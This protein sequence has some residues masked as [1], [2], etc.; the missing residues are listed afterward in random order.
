MDRY[1]LGIDIG[2]TFTDAT[3]IN[4]GTGELRIG[5]VSSTPKD[6]SVG[7]LNAAHRVLREAR[8]KP[9][10][11]AYVVHGTTVANN[12]IIEGKLASTAF[13]TTDGFRDLLEIQRQIRPSLYDLQFDKP[14]P[15]VPRYLCYGVPGRLDAQGNV[16]TPLDEGAVR[17]VIEQ[18][19]KEK[20]Q[21]VA[22]CALHSYVNPAHE[23][24]TGELIKELFPE[25]MVSL[26]CEVA[27]EVREYFRAS[28]TVINAGL[29][30]IVDRYLGRIEAGLRDSGLEADPLVMQSSGGVLTFEA[31][32]ERPVFL[33]ESGPAAGV[34]AAN[35]LGDALGHRNLISLD[36]GGTTAKIGLI[37]D[38][39]PR[40]T[41]DYEVGAMATA[42]GHGSKGG[43][44]PIRTPVIDLIEIGAGGGSIAWVDSGGGLRVGPH[45]AGADPGPVCYGRGGTEPTV[46][47]ANL[48]LGRLD[49]DYF[50]GGE[51][52]LDAEGA[53]RAISEKCADPLGLDLVKVAVGI[54]EIANTAMV[55]ALKRISVQRGFDPRDFVMVCFGGAGPAHANRL[56][57]EMD[58]P[59]TMIPMSPGTTSALGLLVT[60]L[61]H[62]YSTALI[63]RADRLDLGS[64]ERTFRSMEEQGRQLLLRERTPEDKISFLRQADMRYVGQSYE[65]TV[66]LA[67]GKM[68]TAKLAQV[69]ERFHQEHERAYGYS[70]PQE[71]VEF[72]ALRLKAIG[73]IAKPQ[74]RRLEPQGGDLLAAHLRTRQVYF[75]E[76]DGYVDCSIYDRYRLGADA[77]VPGPAILQELDS[78]IVVHP[79][80][81]AMV[82]EFGNLFLGSA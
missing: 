11:V 13:I 8:V 58:I 56:A 27:P 44:Y 5:K 20:V 51:V 38:G 81:E 25:A 80:Y 32:R 70:A 18:L 30:P 34:I 69:E 61:K 1:R 14:R 23:K 50:L 53:R 67:D 36:M 42:A 45:S 17:S 63:E 29:Q 73:K 2:G 37:H 3:L 72:V 41:K 77:L 55:N 40:E 10:E 71:P 66:L 48:V 33:V 75:A 12:A 57:A 7:F 47:D 82:D 26:S 28:T 68:D 62:D 39:T 19:K 78:T 16:V 6:P 43:G 76:A 9:E 15:L 74:L 21:S 35:F 54:V 65:L 24:R 31:A 46:T 79:G 52:S 60:D 4:E 22:V 49:P 64:M 59:R